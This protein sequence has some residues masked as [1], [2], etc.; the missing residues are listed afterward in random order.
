MHYVHVSL[1]ITKWVEID[2]SIDEDD[3]KAGE[4]GEIPGYGLG[5]LC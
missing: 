5:T 2:A 3:R 1:L 4:R